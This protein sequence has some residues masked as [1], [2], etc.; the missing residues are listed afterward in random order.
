MRGHGAAQKSAS[1]G[2]EWVL[3]FESLEAE[4]EDVELAV[5]GRLPTWL[6]GTLVRNGPALFAAGERELN[7]WFDGFAMLHGFT[8]DGGQVRYA[9]RFLETEAYRSVREEG[10]LAV[11]E[12]GTDPCRSI[13]ERVTSLFSSE[14]TDNACVSVAR[15]AGEH[16]AMTETPL[17]VR[18]DPATLETGTRLDWA[19]ELDGQLTTAHP[20]HD[21]HREHTV[22]YVTRMGRSSDYRVF[23]VPDDGGKPRIVAELDVD[24]PAYMHSFALTDE[25]VLLAEFPLVVDPLRLALSEEPFIDSFRWEPER[26]TRWRI[27]D[28]W[29]GEEV[30]QASSEAIFAFHHVNA[31]EADGE[32]VAD[33]C[34]YPDATVIDELFLD[35]LRSGKPPSA[36]AVARPVRARVPLD[37]GE[38]EIEQLSDASLELPRIDPARAR[39]AH[40][41]VYGIGHRNDPPEAF[42]NRIVKLDVEDTN[43]H[44]WAEPGCYPGEPVFV[45]RPERE[46]EDDGVLLSIVLDG[47]HERSFLLVLDAANLEEIARAEAPHAIPFGFHGAFFG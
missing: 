27:V 12:F 36:S 41:Y 23:T 15:M 11:G 1:T 9:N 3:G 20:H 39:Q 35:G 30:A 29:T 46:A 4:R 16:V 21:E 28:R 19:G 25:H 2:E 47:E 40:R 8:L 7:H 37:G 38:V 32:I 34:A 44:T 5:Q 10:E 31:F 42:L 43:T 18:F 22:N 17:P 13:F 26:G 24:E 6:K 45:P 33:L 14:L